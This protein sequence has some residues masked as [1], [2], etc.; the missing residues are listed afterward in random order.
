MAK[1]KVTKTGELQATLRNVLGIQL[2]SGGK[3]KDC[4]GDLIQDMKKYKVVMTKG[5]ETIIPQ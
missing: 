1:I 2:I 3:H 4:N 5:K